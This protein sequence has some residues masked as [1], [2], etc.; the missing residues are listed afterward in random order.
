SETVI[1][2]GQTLE[3]GTDYS[4]SYDLGQ[5]TF[6]DPDGLFGDRPGNVTVRFEERGIFAV[7]PTTIYG[8][9]STYTVG[10]AG[11]FNLIGIYQQENTVFNRPPVGFEPSANLVGGLTGDFR[12]RPAG[13]TRLMSSLVS[14][15]TEAPSTLDLKGEVAFTAPQANRAGAA[16]LE[17][18]E[19]T[20]GLELNLRENAWGFG[21]RPERADGVE[22]LGFVAGFDSAD[23]VQLTWQNLILGPNGTAVE[24]RTRDI[25][26]LVRLSGGA[27]PVE[28]VLYVTLHADTAGGF[29]RR[30]NSSSWTLP[31]RPD[32]PRWRSF[33]T[34]LSTTGIDL[35]QDEYLEFWLFE[36]ASASADSAHV[37]LVMDLGTVNEDGLFIAPES[38]SVSG[39]DSTWGGRRYSGVGRLDTE[40][41]P[42][43][44]FNASLDDIG[45]GV[46]RPDTLVVNGAVTLDTPTCGQ[47]LTNA[48]PLYRWGDL[49]VRCTRGNG[50]MDTEDLNGDNVLNATGPGDNVF[51]WVVDLRD[52]KYFVRTG[53]TGWR[54]YRIPLRN[55][56]AQIGTPNARLVQ[57]LRITVAAGSDNGLPDIVGRF[58]LARMRFL[59][60]PW[61][62]RSDAPV[63]GLSGA[64]AEPHGE[65]V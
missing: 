15:G 63:L 30:D 36:G 7:A 25:D 58:A 6:L 52:P 2:N 50:T 57:H 3:R 1:A 47:E 54:L 22:G 62:R 9:T 31:E 21:S 13:V 49:G 56:D 34:P 65:V 33:V 27:D 11:T 53:G 20:T 40:R 35:T 61:V 44:V 10:E 32:R 17:E 23:A 45:I 4:I 46:D 42:T 18:F 51:R 64:T 28:K 26:S 37:A 16:Y 41:E 8:L 55:W 59:G 24:V 5:V 39:A 43:G 48:V 12:F 29:V 19:G 14:G 60:A 38:L